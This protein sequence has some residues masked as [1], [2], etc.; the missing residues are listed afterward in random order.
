MLD[1]LGAF[2]ANTAAFAANAPELMRRTPGATPAVGNEEALIAAAKQRAASLGADPVD[3]ELR[4]AQLTGDLQTD[5]KLLLT[6]QLAG[7]ADSESLQ[8]V[9]EMGIN[10]GVDAGKDVV[11]YNPNADA[12]MLAHELGHGVSAKTK[13]GKQIRNLRSNPKLAMA[14]QMAGLITPFGVA[15]AIPGDDDVAASMTMAYGALAPTLI[16]EALATKNG[17][18][19]MKDAGRPATPKQRAR[20][21]A[22][23][24][25]YATAPLF[26]GLILNK[27]GNVI[28]KN[29]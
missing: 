7:H 2:G 8:R 9:R 1:L 28:D 16:D 29:E 25:S 5:A 10:P 20:M 4:P 21:A 13:V 23:Y 22:A 19:I 17:L 12:S 15:A 26:G 27:M 3:Y 6:N 18:A 24:L 11:M 14:A